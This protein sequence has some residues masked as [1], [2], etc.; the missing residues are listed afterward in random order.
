MVTSNKS[1][2]SLNRR[3]GT[4]N[5]GHLTFRERHEVEFEPNRDP[6]FEIL[7]RETNEGLSQAA[8]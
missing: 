3:A 2:S 4:R 5:L 6:V 7:D 1:Y 8:Y